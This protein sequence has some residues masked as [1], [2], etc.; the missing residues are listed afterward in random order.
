V[1]WLSKIWPKSL[2]WQLMLAVALGLLFV[3]GVGAA[4]YYFADAKMATAQAASILRERVANQAERVAE[5]GVAWDNTGRS[6]NRT[7]QTRREEN[8]PNRRA[9]RSNSVPI[10]VTNSPIITAG[11]MADDALSQQAA[12]L[13]QTAGNGLDEVRVATGPIAGLPVPLAQAALQS[14]FSQRL[15]RQQQRPP[16]KAILLTAK[17][18]DGQWINAV[19]A[20]RPPDQWALLKLI[21]WTVLL[22]AGAMI[23]LALA[24]RRIVKPLMRLND[25]VSRIGITE[26]FAPLERE[27]PADVQNL[28]D[29]FNK[30]Q[31]RVSSLL[32]EKDVMLGAIGHD[33]KTPLAALRVRIESVEDDEEREKMADTIDEM[34]AILDDILTLARLGRSGEAAVQTDIAAL[35][36]TIAD[37]FETAGEIVSFIE[38]ERRIIAI[39]RPVMIR[40]ALRNLIGNAVKHGGGAAISIAAVVGEIS[41]NIDD[42]GPGIPS[43]TIEDMFTP[44]VRAESSR[45]RATGGS[46]LGLTIAR[47]IARSHQGDVRLANRS[48]GGLRATLQLQE[49]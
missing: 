46:G 5:R 43:D 38:P 4:V 19:A 40:R 9:R 30:M 42:N 13:L 32:G 20:L 15:R 49:D 48:N 28:I 41:I 11:F 33:L 45:N 29:S 22:F 31:S 18:A 6:K 16:I 47:A 24:A 36:S 3:Q 1:Q 27:G 21:L 25:R 35:V 26:E 34:V 8:R 14:R 37:E 17:A 2:Y 12:I 7:G 44:F 10:I 39:I 23:P